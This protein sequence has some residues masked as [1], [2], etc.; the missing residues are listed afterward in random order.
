MKVCIMHTEMN[1]SNAYCNDLIIQLVQAIVCWYDFNYFFW[2][3]S[4]LSVAGL[5]WFVS[6]VWWIK[7]I[8]K[9]LVLCGN[10]VAAIKFWIELFSIWRR[11]RSF[12]AMDIRYWKDCIRHWIVSCW[13]AGI[14]QLAAQRKVILYPWF[15]IFPA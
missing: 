13:T 8:K 14:T 1:E 2:L 12:S 9:V 11:F 10:L 3:V 6:L 5:T 4:L 15:R 7:L